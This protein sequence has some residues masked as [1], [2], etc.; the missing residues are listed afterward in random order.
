MKIREIDV[1]RH[2][3]VL[4]KDDDQDPM[5]IRAATC[6]RFLRYKNARRF[7]KPEVMEEKWAQLRLPLRRR[8]V[9]RYMRE[10]YQRAWLMANL[11]DDTKSAVILYSYQALCW[12]LGTEADCL[13]SETLLQGYRH[14][15]K[16]A[17]V[18]LG[19]RY[20]LGDWRLY[21]D[22]LWR[23]ED[24]AITITAEEALQ[25]W[26]AEFPLLGEDIR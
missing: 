19:S 24:P 5:G 23:M 1:V 25:I 22:D 6:V 20:P 2:I 8:N 13:F 26:K 9:L 15:G 18:R 16:P 3:L 4:R 12:L 11:A 7:L 21:D 17:L 14:F 10:L